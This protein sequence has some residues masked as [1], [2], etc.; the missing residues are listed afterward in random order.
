MEISQR[1]LGMLFVWAVALGFMLG[2]VY[3]VL[4]IT[5]ILCGVHYVKRFSQDERQ[6]ADMDLM[7]V[8]L[9]RP[10]KRVLHTMRSVLIFTE[11]LLFGLV[12]GV[13][14]VILLYYTNDGQLRA[15]ALFGMACGFF[16]YHQTLGRLIMLFSEVIVLAVRRFVR[17]TLRLVLMPIQWLALLLYRI[18]GRRVA[19][20]VKR[21]RYARR[22]RYTDKVVDARVRLASQGFGLLDDVADDMQSLEP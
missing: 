12:C 2:V 20:L 3:D 4:R 15:L 10:R 9:R 19:Q 13:S 21:I 11:D 14:L 17:W 5:H 22:V 8:A 18:I 6:V 16:V 7:S 1:L